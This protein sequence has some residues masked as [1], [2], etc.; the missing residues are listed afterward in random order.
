MSNGD[1]NITV[2][3]E[4]A[5]EYQNSPENERYVALDADGKFRAVERL[6]ARED[7]VFKGLVWHAP[8]FESVGAAMERYGEEVVLSVFNDKI[9]QLAYLRA[10]NGVKSRLSDDKT[11]WAEEVQA[12]YPTDKI[13]F[14]V[15]DV[16]AFKPGEREQ[17]LK[18]LA[19]E[20]N[21]ANKQAQKL[22][23]DGNFEAAKAEMEKAMAAMEK[24]QRINMQR[25]QQIEAATDTNE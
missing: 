2:T 4:A 1:T 14:S 17:T 7:S 24:I 19:N 8:K 10:V 16:R 9:E 3:P 21:K 11:K 12:L 15:D 23:A 13:I 22:M 6:I 5:T 18:Q 20:M 25:L